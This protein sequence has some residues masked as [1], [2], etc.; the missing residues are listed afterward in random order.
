MLSTLAQM[1][2]MKIAIRVSLPSQ[3]GSSPVSWAGSGPAS[4]AAVS[5][6]LESAVTAA[7]PATSSSTHEAKMPSPA[8]SAIEVLL[9]SDLR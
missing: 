3:V 4:S 9:V 1:A 5:E 8:H 6:L 7:A 2:P